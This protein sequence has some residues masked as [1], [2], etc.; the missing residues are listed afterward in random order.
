M[1]VYTQVFGG[2]TIYPSNVSYLALALTADVTLSWPL[3]ANTGAD[4]AARIIDVTPTGAFSIFMPPADQTGVGQTTLF[5]NLGPDTITVKDSVGGTLISIAAG[6]QWQIYLTDNTTAAGSWRVFRYGAATAQA[7]ASALAGLGLVAQGSVLS[8]TYPTVTFNSNYTA[9]TPDRAAFYV[10][11]GG[12]GTLTLPSA[13]S[14]GN[15]FF[16]AARNGGSGNLTVTPDGSDD[17]NGA[18]TLVLRPGDSAVCNSDGVGWYTVG[19]GQDAVFAFDYTSIDLTSETS[20]YVLSGA[21]LNR[22]AYEFIGT[23]TANME[24]QVPGTTQQYWVSN[25]T[26]GAY[27]LGVGLL[28]QSPVADVPQG[29]RGIYYSNG[30]DV[31]NAATAG[32]AVPLAISDGGTGATSAGGAL[33]NLG[34]TTVGIAVFTAVDAEAARAAI[35]T[36]STEDSYSFA[37]A[38]S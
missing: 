5:N 24:I 35:G 29:S 36:P 38:I 13:A 11:T 33:I 4:V 10:W 32:I 26:S 8:Q 1:S 27:T 20:P 37:V 14:A 28:G 6:Q 2:T 7:Q 12:V 15:G 16:I 31:V 22:I 18:A 9:G 23:L 3:D 25:A 17:I 30:V 21:E 19:F 34:G